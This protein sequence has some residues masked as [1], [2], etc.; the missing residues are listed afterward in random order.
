L[1]TVPINNSHNNQNSN[2]SSIVVLSMLRNEI[3]DTFTG[4]LSYSD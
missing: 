1:T 2:L 3:P 4:T